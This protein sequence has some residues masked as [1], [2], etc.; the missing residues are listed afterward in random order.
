MTDEDWDKRFEEMWADYLIEVDESIYKEDVGFNDDPEELQK[1]FT[2]LEEK[3]LTLIH[4][5]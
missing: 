2:D 4:N 5:T 3:N 1:I